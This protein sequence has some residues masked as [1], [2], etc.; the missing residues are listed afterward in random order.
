MCHAF[1]LHHLARDASVRRAAAN[2]EVVRGGDHR[3]AIDQRLA[4]EE[5][6]GGDGLEVAVVVVMPLASDLADLAERTGVAY[7]REPCAGVHLAARVLARNL[8]RAAHL[9]GQRLTSAE[10]FE[11]FLPRHPNLRSG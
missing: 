3:A 8:V 4:E 2:G 11:F 5:G 6:G 10:F 7:G 9:F 1:G